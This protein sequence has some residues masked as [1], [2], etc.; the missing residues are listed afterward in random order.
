MEGLLLDVQD[1]E[2]RFHTNDGIVHALNGV[3]FQLHQG[4]ALAIV[5]E[6]GCGKSVTMMS[7]LRLLPEPPGEVVGGKALFLD[8]DLLKMSSKEIRSIR[9]MHIGMIFQD[10]MTALNPSMSIGH[11]LTEGLLEHCQMDAKQAREEALRLLSKVGISSPGDRFNDFPHQFSGGM[12]QRVMI[13]IA[14][15]CRPEVLIADESTTA[16]DVTIQAQIVDLMLELRKE[17]G[18]SIIW[19]THDLSVIAR[20]VDKVAVMY[21]GRMVEQTPISQLYRNPRH[22]YTIGLLGALPRLDIV[23][24]QR[25]VNIQGAPPYMLKKPHCC[26]F[27]PRCPYVQDECLQQL[28][29]LRQ[30]GDM[31]TTAC[32][33]DID[34]ALDVWR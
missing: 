7:I 18:M 29:A 33:F 13:A 17:M 2:Y 22:P 23:S 4:E 27:A 8:R 11:Q 20:M 30:V 16:L 9:G 19:V 15:A 24:S 5:G 26:S 1:L 6:S 34:R 14:L 32:L 12:R 3:S 25:L 31:H 28:P 21:A 10:P